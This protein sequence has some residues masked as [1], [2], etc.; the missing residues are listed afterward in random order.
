MKA[1]G[2]KPSSEV[3]SWKSPCASTLSLGRRTWPLTKVQ[4]GPRADLDPMCHLVLVCQGPQHAC[5]QPEPV[6]PPQQAPP[7]QQ[8]HHPTDHWS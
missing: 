2:R 8:L 6:S 7:R 3:D 4:C 1:D 5:T